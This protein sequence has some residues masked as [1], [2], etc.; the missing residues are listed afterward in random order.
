MPDAQ[1]F[2]QVGEN[3]VINVV[4]IIFEFHKLLL[5]SIRRATVDKTNHGVLRLVVRPKTFRVKPVNVT[6]DFSD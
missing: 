1:D 2:P 6:L 3:F 4:N 5:D